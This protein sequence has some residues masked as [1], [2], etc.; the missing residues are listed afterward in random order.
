M[1]DLTQT[2]QEILGSKEGQEKLKNVAEMLGGGE[3][4]GFDLSSLG[5][6]F[7]GET[8]DPQP[9]ESSE[10]DPFGGL[11]INMLMQVKNM[12]STMNKDDKNVNLI[13][14]IKPHLKPERQ[15]KADEAMKIMKL[16]SLL[17]TLKESGLLG[18]IGL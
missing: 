8:Q 4:Q 7:G 3:G 15:A 11:D 5:S 18:K 12:M 17:P 1:E 14:A 10:E 9:E 2:L 6:L 13:R 16:I